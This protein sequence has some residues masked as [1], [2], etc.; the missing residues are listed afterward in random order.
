MQTMGLDSNDPFTNLKVMARGSACIGRAG[1]DRAGQGK[2][3]HQLKVQTA[4]IG[5][6]TFSHYSSF[7]NKAQK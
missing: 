2:L 4:Q 1:Q 7:E 3:E 5:L 6:V